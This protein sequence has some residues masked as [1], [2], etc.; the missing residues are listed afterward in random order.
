MLLQ[1][2]KQIKTRTLY[3][4]EDLKKVSSQGSK[5]EIPNFWWN[6]K[7]KYEISKL[8]QIVQSAPKLS[9]YLITKLKINNSQLL[10]SAHSLH[11]KQ[12]KK[13]N[14]N[15]WKDFLPLSDA[16]ILNSLQ[17]GK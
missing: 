11:C 15:Y 7:A 2:H 16:Q 1:Q 3:K 14:K 5:T 10:I 13:D 12:W 6:F 17:L 8:L 9:R 4:C